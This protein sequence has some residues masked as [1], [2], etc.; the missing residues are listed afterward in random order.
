MMRTELYKQQVLSREMSSVGIKKYFIGLKII[1]A[2]V[3]YALK[4]FSL[5]YFFLK[6]TLRH[7]CFASASV[8]KVK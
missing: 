5:F 8:R 4:S 2:T 7:P 1:S 3:H 6:E